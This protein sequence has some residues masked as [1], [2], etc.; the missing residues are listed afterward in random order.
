MDIAN[1]VE[2]SMLRPLVRPHRLTHKR[3]S[4]NLLFSLENMNLPKPL[5]LELAKGL[6]KLAALIPHNVRAEVAVGTVN[7]SVLAD[8]LWQIE[9]NNHRDNVILT[10]QLEQ[11]SSSIRLNIRR[12]HDHQLSE[13][14]TFPGNVVQKL[15]SVFR[16]SL[17]I[18]VIR[19][20]SA[21]SI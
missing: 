14:Q 15:E 5:S 17:V 13:S 8:S 6:S 4:F 18:L 9:D 20:H 2:R 11:T 12:I 16:Y 19:H 21:T 1:D 10:S 3:R 7:V